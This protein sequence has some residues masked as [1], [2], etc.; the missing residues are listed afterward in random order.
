MDIVF[1][2][3]DLEKLC[4]KE[5]AAVRKLGKPCAKKLKTRLADL[6]SATRVTDLVAGSPHPLTGD[7]AGQ[8]AVALHGGRRLVFEAANEPVPLK[9]DDGIDWNLVTRIRVLFIGDYHD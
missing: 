6:M 8:F 2:A 3:P 5:A 7:R 1:N 9:D 4:S